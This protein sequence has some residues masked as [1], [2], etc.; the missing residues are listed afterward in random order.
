MEPNEELLTAA[1]REL[2][3]ETGY[4]LEDAQF[5]DKIVYS[6]ESGI[7]V[8]HTYLVGVYDKIQPIQCFEG[9]KMQFK[10]AQEIQLLLMIPEAK[11][12][13]LGILSRLQ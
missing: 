11:R 12:A 9:Q 2:L 1:K 5:G 3:E 6:D 7:P 10:T 8:E 4:Q 13:V